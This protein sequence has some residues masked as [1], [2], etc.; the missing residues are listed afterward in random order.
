M[1]HPAP[2]DR[3]DITADLAFQ[4]VENAAIAEH[5]DFVA[6]CDEASREHRPAPPAPPAY[7]QALEDGHA[8]LPR[9]CGTCNACCWAYDVPEFDKG[10][11][12]T[13]PKLADGLCTVYPDRPNAC[14]EFACDWLRGRLP[15]WASP[16]ATGLISRLVPVQSLSQIFL[17]PFPVI[18]ELSETRAQA[19]AEG[20]QGPA[21]VALLQRDG[22]IVRLTT[23]D[24]AI[25][26]LLPDAAPIDFDPTRLPTWL[27]TPAPDGEGHRLAAGT[28]VVVPEAP[29]FDGDALD[30]WFDEHVESASN[31]PRPL[32]VVRDE[33]ARRIAK[34]F[35]RRLSGIDRLGAEGRRAVR[36]AAIGVAEVFLDGLVQ[37]DDG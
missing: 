1:S 17:C 9:S 25:R 36:D 6:A 14:L 26:L 37:D 24:G 29:R 11:R 10:P 7:R 15:E 20:E 23:H 35:V 2:D 33:L 19:I 28:G 16:E 13:C 12:C 5:P 34:E 31:D 4:D 32:E 21:L 27:F 18:A 3:L 8:L 30:T 22:L